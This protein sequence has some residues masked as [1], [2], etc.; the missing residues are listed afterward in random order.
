MSKLTKPIFGILFLLLAFDFY[1][2]GQMRMRAP[3]QHR[4]MQQRMERM[5]A[6]GRRIEVVKENFI[7]K[8]LLLTP[9]ESR[10]FWPLYRQYM[11]DV[12]AVRIAKRLNNSSSTTDGTEQI[13]KD[14]AYETELLNIKKHYR[15][16]FLKVL[17]PEKVSELYKSEREFTDEMLK[18]LS[19]RTGRP[20]S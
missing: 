20:G 17:P 18:Q 8:R 3:F 10:A 5:P 14:L 4:P 15:D 9:Q 16:E 19:E 1:S 13:N 12:T 6:A 2:F 11:Q 7:S